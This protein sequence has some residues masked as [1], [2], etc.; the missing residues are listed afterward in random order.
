[1]ATIS[2]KNMMLKRK[3]AAKGMSDVIS[4][5]VT[6]IVKGIRSG[7]IKNTGVNI[8]YEKDVPYFY[9][10]PKNPGRII[11]ILNGTEESGVLNRKTGNFSV[12]K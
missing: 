10:D 7:R 9:A 4:N 8:K 5:A 12:R 1:M 3:E 6:T 2:Q 11:R